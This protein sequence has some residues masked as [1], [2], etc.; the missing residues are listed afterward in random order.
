M[1]SNA[2]KNELKVMVL[3][4]LAAIC[5]KVA[6]NSAVPDDL[7]ADARHLVE[8]FEAL[9]PARGKGTP[10]EHARG[11]FLLVKMARFL[12]RIVEVQSWPADSPML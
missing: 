1:D 7:R 11:E 12:S 6:E 4:D 9:L 2:A 3:M 10:S 5:G 8:Q